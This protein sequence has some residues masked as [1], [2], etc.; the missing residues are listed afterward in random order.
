ME[1]DTQIE[2][3]IPRTTTNG[4]LHQART[5]ANFEAAE[6]DTEES[7]IRRMHGIQGNITTR[8]AEQDQSGLGRSS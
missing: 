5:L 4:H 1:R 2:R 8:Q 7:P 6:K 3:Q